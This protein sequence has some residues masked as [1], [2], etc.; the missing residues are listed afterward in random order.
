MVYKHNPMLNPRNASFKRS[1]RALLNIGELSSIIMDHAKASMMRADAL[2]TK[3]A[4]YALSAEEA[5][6]RAF[7]QEFNALEH[8][9]DTFPVRSHREKFH[10]LGANRRPVW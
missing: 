7:F 10:C 5:R 1:I 2:I 9:D 3:F 6:T 8:S 4:T